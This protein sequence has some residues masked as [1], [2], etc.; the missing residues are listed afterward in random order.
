[1]TWGI[2]TPL[3][4]Q[5]H[6][7]LSLA[8]IVSGLIVVFGMLKD[9]HLTV[10]SGAF[11]ATTFLTGV[12]GFPLAP[13]GLD[14]PRVVGGILL[15]LLIA[16]GAALYLFA[17]TGSARSVYVVCSV[18]AL[19]LNVFVAVAQAFQKVAFLRSLA[20]TQSGP[21]FAVTQIVVLVAF[22]V[23]GVLAWRRFQSTSPSGAMR[24]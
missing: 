4:L 18:A 11:L 21:I 14:P 2:P 5:L 10:W 13:F 8:G 15:C 3:F 17:R 19:Y 7:A 22:I 1:M 6:V 20:S 23:I 9:R 24:A 12:T 16:A